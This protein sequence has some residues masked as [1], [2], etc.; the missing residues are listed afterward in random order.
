MPNVEDLVIDTKNLINNFYDDYR[1]R[2]AAQRQELEI[3]D[4]RS[5]DLKLEKRD[6]QGDLDD[7]NMGWSKQ[8]RKLYSRMTASQLKWD[9]Y[10]QALNRGIKRLNTT[11]SY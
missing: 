5:Y 7:L 6:Y 11:I 1:G 2:L 3:D 8:W 4:M 10:Y 9:R